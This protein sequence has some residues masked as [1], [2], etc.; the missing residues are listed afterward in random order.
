MILATIATSILKQTFGPNILKNVF[1]ISKGVFHA[2]GVHV[3]NLKV[4]A[5]M[6]DVSQRDPLLL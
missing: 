4:L 2:I 3:E 6:T 5:R 1:T